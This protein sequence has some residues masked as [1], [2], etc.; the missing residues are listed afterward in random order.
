MCPMVA[1][2]PTDHELAKGAKREISIN[3]LA[4]E[5]VLIPEPK[6]SPGYMERLHQLCRLDFTPASTQ[7]VKGLENLL[8]MVAAGYGVS[9]LPEV[10]ITR[11]DPIYATRRLRA[12]VPKFHLKLLWLRGASSMVL[13][14]FLA[15][16]KR[17]AAGASKQ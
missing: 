11:S 9:I 8:G 3:K 1:V 14:N 7:S 12:P 4:G 10:L 15:V 16:A 6:A 2:M 13:Q 5:T 17:Y